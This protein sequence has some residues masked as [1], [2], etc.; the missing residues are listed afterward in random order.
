MEGDHQ[1][2]CCHSS[3]RHTTACLSSGRSTP[4][5]DH[6]FPARTFKAGGGNPVHTPKYGFIPR[7]LLRLPPLLLAPSLSPLFS[8]AAEPSPASTPTTTPAPSIL[9]LTPVL[10]RAIRELGLERN[11]RMPDR[12][13]GKTH[14]RRGMIQEEIHCMNI[15]TRMSPDARSLYLASQEFIDEALREHGL[16]L[17]S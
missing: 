9:L 12:T 8:P 5:R 14:V 4:G 2:R 7:L 1:C 13:R 15:F 16:P 3:S 11:M 17:R 10:D 6:V